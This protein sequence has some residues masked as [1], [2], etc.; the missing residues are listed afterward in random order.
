MNRTAG[1]C[2]VSLFVL[3]CSSPQTSRDSF[4]SLHLL[5]EQKLHGRWEC[6]PV[7]PNDV[8][9]GRFF[10]VRHPNSGCF[11]VLSERNFL[12]QSDW[13]KRYISGTNLLSQM[14]AQM[15]T[16]GQVDVQAARQ[17]AGVTNMFGL[18]DLPGWSYRD[19]GVEVDLQEP[20]NAYPGNNEDVAKARQIYAEIV[21]LLK[22]Y[23]VR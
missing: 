9:G 14:M 15:E 11:I 20:E 17:F 6:G 19:I 16:N 5:V 4:A 8:R 7:S 23:R 10:E 21:S 3:G 1:F 22:P 13:E 2:L 12:S 18:L